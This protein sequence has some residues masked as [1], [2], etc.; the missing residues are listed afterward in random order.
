MQPRRSA[1]I[2]CLVDIHTESGMRQIEGSLPR[3]RK[4][5]Y[6][7]R[8]GSRHQLLFDDLFGEWNSQVK[9]ELRQVC[10]HLAKFLLS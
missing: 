4:F 2:V 8:S 10:L 6:W 7:Y 5:V 9:R 1:K 3:R